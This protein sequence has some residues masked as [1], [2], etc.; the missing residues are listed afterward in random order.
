MPGALVG[1]ANI[2]P[3]TAPS[4][5]WATFRRVGHAAVRVYRGGI[6]STQ[7]SVAD[8]P[9]ETPVPRRRPPMGLWL[10]I[11]AGL[12]LIVVMGIAALYVVGT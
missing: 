6:M 9:S 12:V 5:S 3:M 2:T 10:H 1:D 8:E 4:S 7:P 11:G